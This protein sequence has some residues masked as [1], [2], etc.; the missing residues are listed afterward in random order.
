M[1]IPV[2]IPSGALPVT[3]A[4]TARAE[5][6]VA[7]LAQIIKNGTSGGTANI[8]TPATLIPDGLNPGIDPATGLPRLTSVSLAT[9]QEQLFYRQLALAL[10]Q[11]L[12]PYASSTVAG[13]TRLSTD[14][15]VAS[16]PI[17]T[18]SEEVSVTPAP[19]K[20]PRA[21]PSGTIDPGWVG[22]GPGP[23]PFID[24]VFTGTCLAT[25]IVGDIVRI[26]GAGMTVDKADCTNEAKMLAVGVIISKSGSTSCVVQTN[27]IVSGVYTGL[28]PGSLYF[29]GSNGRPTTTRPSP[30]TGGSVLVQP[31][32]YALDAN[33][34]LVSPGTN[35]T[36]MRG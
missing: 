33:L 25:N 29:V 14:P 24:S 12:V 1:A 30:P 13:I 9:P 5:A 31:I 2:P 3:D 34:F 4:D 28:T 20:I 21:G 23:G 8:R 16:L 7:V 35:I 18:N 27:D 22:A 15:A 6:L 11:A 10:S 36:R 17:A 19:N 32:G 26:T